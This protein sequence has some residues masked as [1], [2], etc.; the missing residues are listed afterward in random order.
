MVSDKTIHMA[1]RI[2]KTNQII[3]E[4]M[5]IFNWYPRVWFI[6]RNERLTCR[7]CV[8]MYLVPVAGSRRVREALVIMVCG[9]NAAWWREPSLDTLESL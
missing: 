3:K 4:N 7:S 1:C 5:Q 9:M 6:L 2:H 8:W